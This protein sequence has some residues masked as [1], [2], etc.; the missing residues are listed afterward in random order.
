[1]RLLFALTITLLLSGC[2]KNESA[3]TDSLIYCSANY[4]QSFN[5]QISHDISTLDATTHQLYNRLVKIDPIND[6]FI[7]DLATHWQ[8]SD[9]KLSFT[10]FLRKDVTFQQTDYFTPTRN[11]NADDLIFSFQRMIN[12]EQPFHATNRITDNYF[13][14]HSFTNLV[15]DIVKIDD[16][17][18]KFILNKPDVTLLAHLAA[19]YGVI[20]SKEYAQNLLA[21]GTPEKID[22]YP[23]GTG[24]YKFKNADKRT[25]IIRYLSHATYWQGSPTIKNLIFDVTG[26]NT[27]RHSKLLSGECDVITSPAPSQL[28]TILANP[29]LIT[30]TKT[31]KNIALWSF[32]SLQKPFD[33]KEIRR[34]LSYAIDQKRIINA[35]FP[36]SAIVTNGLLAKRS[37]AYN[38]IS[39]ELQYSPELAKNMLEKNN[40]NFSRIIS[41]LIP[42][43]NDFFNPNFKKTAEL[44]KANLFA[45]GVKSKIIPLSHS[46]LKR[47]LASAHYDT[48][49]TGVNVHVDDPDSLFRPLLS[50]DSSILQGNSSQWCSKKVQ[51]LL[52]SSLLE[53]NF[54]KRV[55]NYH[56]LQEIIQQERPYYPIAHLLR[57]DVFNQNISGLLVNPLTG[58]DFQNVRKIEAH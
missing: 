39:D 17:K 43:E 42:S 50:C 36:Q 54:A 18:V 41:I 25:G 52:D 3:I 27:K 26:N 6:G 11:F 37:W 19:H 2:Y 51:H 16:Y 45:I 49:L 4:P 53:S 30:S 13:F 7:P 33:Q 8:Q 12:K 40:F 29:R 46:K 38:P 28:N 35:I 34:A 21:S 31:T 47:R 23:I 14:N 55:I 56:K 1:M 57:I 44:I 9:D 10:F 24:P 22:F 58:I 32:N 15:A 5:P 48:Y 20:L